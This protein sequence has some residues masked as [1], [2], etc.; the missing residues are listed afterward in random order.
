M[1]Q[2]E[3]PVAESFTC[4]PRSSP[5]VE[6]S[7]ELTLRIPVALGPQTT[8]Y[9]LAFEGNR[10]VSSSALGKI[11]ELKLGQPLSSVELEAARLRVLDAYRLRGFAYADVRADTEPSPDRSRARVRFYVTERERVTVSDLVVKGAS[12]TSEALILGRAA[13]KRGDYYRQDWV[14]QTEERVAT[15][16]TF[17]SVSVTLEDAE[18]P[19]MRK[20]V[21]ITVAEQPTQYIEQRPGFSTGDGLRYTFEYGHRNLGGVAIGLTLRVQLSYLP[22][23]FILDPT[24]LANYSKLTLVQR[25]ERRDTISVAFHDIGLGPLF[26]LTLDAI[27]LNDNQRDYGLSKEALGPTVTYRPVRNFSAQLGFSTE[28]NNIIV[29]D[30]TDTSSSGLLRA[31]QGRT[32]ALAE[33]L[34]LTYD[35]RDN[36]FNPTRGVLLA[37]T[38]E[39]VNAWPLDAAATVTSHFFRIT[40]RAT[41]YLTKWGIT[42][43]TSLGM[44]GNVQLTSTS[45]S[46]PDRLFF[47]GGVDTN[48]AYLDSSL[49][50]QDV[51]DLV[52][53]VTSP[54][55]RDPISGLP[56]QQRGPQSGLPTG[57][58]SLTI[59]DVPLRGG[60]L[61]INPRVE[62][63][64]PLFSNLQAEL[65]LD[66]ANLWISASEVHFNSSFMRY[67]LGPGLRYV[68]P[69][70]PVSIDYGFNLN[71][72]SWEDVGAFHFSIGQF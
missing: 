20:R 35:L 61:S 59:A 13:L 40:G 21:V 18:V 51:A 33:R 69:I 32:L 6:C 66:M 29:F 48:R 16:G 60:D 27:D 58:R 10:V 39:Q 15:L 56:L 25:L 57:Q 45:A 28:I 31:P 62:L 5:G 46:Y 30:D 64:F 12:R 41:G 24:V 65:F 52:R 72:R 50:P 38:V 68:T 47:V 17:S 9:D 3:P 26:G 22:D 36:P 7:P 2:P 67:G 63:L 42:L 19:A 34:G 55:G 14:R 11:A 44:G 43:A 49:V 23:V 70:G 54:T 8:L 1:P 4:R 37:T 71:P 53:T